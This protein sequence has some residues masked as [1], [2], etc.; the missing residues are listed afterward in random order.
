[1]PRCL[2]FPK[3]MIGLAKDP[4]IKV[5]VCAVALPPTT[6]EAMP[7]H[8]GYLE[9]RRT[10]SMVVEPVSPEARR[11]GIEQNPLDQV[12]LPPP[13][14]FDCKR[15]DPVAS[16]FA[17]KQHLTWE[18]L[19]G[20]RM[21]KRQVSFDARVQPGNVRQLCAHMN[22]RGNHNDAKARF[23]ADCYFLLLDVGVARAVGPRRRWPHCCPSQ[24][25]GRRSRKSGDGMGVPF[26]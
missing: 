7:P 3:Y 22:A 13:L 25:H 10:A 6:I 12:T 11:A 5:G 19:C 17:D 1:M 9:V 18:S 21:V 20:T 2:V 14:P 4:Y 26:L 24:G 23:V 15:G 8:A 16:P